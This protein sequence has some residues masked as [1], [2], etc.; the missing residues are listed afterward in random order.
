M[1]QVD[2][3]ILN[4]TKV[5]QF[6]CLLTEKAFKKGH[7]VHLLTTDENQ[8]AR[9]DKLL[10]TYN[11]QSFLPH[12][13]INDDSHTSEHESQHTPQHKSQHELQK[14]TPIHISHDDQNAL[15]SDVLINLRSEIPSFYQQ[16]NRIAELVSS[17]ERQRQAARVQYREYQQRGCTVASHQITSHQTNR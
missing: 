6:A 2:F 10:W 3:Y 4:N 11:D 13:A 1:T 12:V 9:M 8:T 15:L 14:E 17:D 16:F 7:K 5:E